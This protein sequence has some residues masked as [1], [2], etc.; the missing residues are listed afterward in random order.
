MKITMITVYLMKINIQIHTHKRKYIQKIQQ[1]RSLIA[2]SKII[3]YVNNFKIDNLI[4]SGN[5]NP[6]F[7]LS[8]DKSNSADIFTYVKSK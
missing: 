4:E 7:S 8:L 1:N 3:A 2:S 6:Y 5:I